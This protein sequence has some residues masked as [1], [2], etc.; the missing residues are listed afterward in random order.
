M[1]AS[2]R[3]CGVSMLLMMSVVSSGCSMSSSGSLAAR[4]GFVM[5]AVG[6]T[7]ET[8]L[9][10]GD[11]FPKLAATDID[12]N[13]VTLDEQLWGERY[14][15]LVFWSTWCGFCML[16][17]P[18]EVELSRQYE[19]QGLRVIGVNADDSPEIARQAVYKHQVPW[20]TIFEG[21]GQEISKKLDIKKW[22]ELLLLDSQGRVVMT[23]SELR[24]ISVETLPDG[25]DQQLTGLD[26]A[27]RK[28]LANDDQL[29][30]DA[31][32]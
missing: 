32:K 2:A 1:F 27:L 10:I 18:H 22:P 9:R 31:A 26:W 29:R 24:A 20:L 23:S 16:E 13:A 7:T 11:T 19:A 15:L 8:V 17:L 14:T 28:L 12:G 30:E 6:E 3:R 5:P 4:P 21:S 25:T